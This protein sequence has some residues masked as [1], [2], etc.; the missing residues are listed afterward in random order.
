MNV[1]RPFESVQ[2][3]GPMPLFD[4]TFDQRRSMLRVGYQIGRLKTDIRELLGRLDSSYSP[5]LLDILF[6][7]LMVQTWFIGNSDPLISNPGSI[8]KNSFAECADFER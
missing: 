1:V 5:M 4:L 6:S 8:S 7:T 3:Y 2:R